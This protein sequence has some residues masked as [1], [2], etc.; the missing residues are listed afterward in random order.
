MGDEGQVLLAPLS[1]LERLLGR[2]R[3]HRCPDGTVE[4]AVQNVKGASLHGYAVL[5][6]Q[7][8]DAASQNVVLGDDFLDVKCVLDPL[9]PVRGRSAIDDGQSDGLVRAGSERDDDFRQKIRDMIVE[10]RDVEIAGARKYSNLG[11][12]SSEQGLTSV[13]NQLGKFF[14]NVDDPFLV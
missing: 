14:E 5:R 9:Q 2:E 4:N 13:V 7:V 12:P 10:R 8:V 3:L 1:D 6:G 11:S